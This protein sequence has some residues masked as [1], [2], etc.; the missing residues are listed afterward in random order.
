MGEGGLTRLRPRVARAVIRAGATDLQ[1]P[2]AVGLRPWSED[3]FL[4]VVRTVV[5]PT[6]TYEKCLITPVFAVRGH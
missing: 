2:G 3:Q 1:A 6:H 5:A 4:T